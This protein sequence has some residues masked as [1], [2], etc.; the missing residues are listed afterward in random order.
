MD[1]ARI[2]EMSAETFE[3]LNRYAPR[4]RRIEDLTDEE[5][6]MIEKA[7]VSPAHAHL[8]ALLED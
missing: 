4:T 7:R 5:L 1:R 6:A 8:D 2:N 3:R